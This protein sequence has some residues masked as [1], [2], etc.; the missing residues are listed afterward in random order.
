LI[1]TFGG[2]LWDEELVAF[3]AMLGIDVRAIVDW[4]AAHPNLS[5]VLEASYDSVFLQFG[6]VVTVL[7]LGRNLRAAWEMAAIVLW[8]AFLGLFVFLM[9]PADGPFAYFDLGASPAQAGY[10]QYFHLLRDQAVT[11]IT[12]GHGIITFPSFHVF[13]AVVATYA[14]R[15]SRWLLAIFVVLNVLNIVATMT[16]GWHYF[17]DV[18][19]GVGLFAVIALGLHVIEAAIGRRVADRKG[20]QSPTSEGSQ[21]M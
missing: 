3:D 11:E 4:A 9:V 2:D 19:G 6:V 5:R 7:A 13:F 1:A 21:G 17:A 8:G 20:G 18:L 16:T 15:R 14:A 10:L 12:E